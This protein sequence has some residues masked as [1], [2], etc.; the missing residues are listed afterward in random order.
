MP[1]ADKPAQKAGF[2]LIMTNVTSEIRNY[3]YNML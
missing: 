1:D 3:C 2:W